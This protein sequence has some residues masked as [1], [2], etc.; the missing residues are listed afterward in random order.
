MLKRLFARLMEEAPAGGDPGAAAIPAA[1]APSEPAAAPAL[2]PLQ[3]AA[4]TPVTIPEKFQVKNEDGTVNHEATAIKLAEGYSTAE[5][6][7]G[8]GDIPPK[9]AS[10]YAITVPKALEGAWNPAEDPQLQAFTEKA[11]GLG[12]TQKQLDLVIESYGEL[13]PGLVAGASAAGA[14]ECTA[15]LKEV[16]PD[17][18]SYDAN[19]KAAA[20]AL[21]TYGGEQVEGFLARYGND[22]DFIKMMAKIG[23]EVGE[24]KSIDA[25][26]VLKG[27]TIEELESSDAYRNPGDPQHKAVSEQ[28]RLY[29]EAKAK[30]EASAGR[31][32]LF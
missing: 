6:R 2:N 26:E 16:W 5:K 28:I 10:E 30:G 15:A 20:R 32:V 22:A 21:Q 7:I 23:A 1:A 4:A 17:Q 8:S 31:S 25:G 9:A 18:A 19:T 11:H 13:A 24:D 29:Y 27:K 3:A 12:F 14:E